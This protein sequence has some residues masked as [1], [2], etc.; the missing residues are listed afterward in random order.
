MRGIANG[1]VRNFSGLRYIK[2]RSCV[3]ETHGRVPENN[4]YT[5]SGGVVPERVFNIYIKDT[6]NG[7]YPLTCN[8]VPRR[9]P[10]TM[11]RRWYD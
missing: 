8:P 6:Y 4:R 10:E 2:R 5:V 7:C 1:Q 9:K 11:L 3:Q